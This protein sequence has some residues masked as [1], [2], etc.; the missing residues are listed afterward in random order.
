MLAREKPNDPAILY[1]EPV[2][3]KASTTF[4]MKRSFKISRGLLKAM[5]I[6]EFAVLAAGR[7]ASILRKGSPCLGLK[8]SGRD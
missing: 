2:E 5:I 3:I 6:S 1:V 4:A 8:S 7:R